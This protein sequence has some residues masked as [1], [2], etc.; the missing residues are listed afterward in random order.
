MRLQAADLDLLLRMFTILTSAANTY[1][2]QSQFAS[3]AHAYAVAILQGSLPTTKDN[4][5]AGTSC[6]LLALAHFDVM[7]LHA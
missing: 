7:F 1:Q 5:T 4:L 6:L 2:E 3:R